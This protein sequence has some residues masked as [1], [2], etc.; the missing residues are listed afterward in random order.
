M[1]V[2]ALSFPQQFVARDAARESDA[3]VLTEDSRRSI[4]FVLSGD[5]PA[6][7]EAVSEALPRLLSL[8][9]NWDGYGSKAIDFELLL[10]AFSELGQI[11]DDTSPRPSMVPLGNG[12][13][14]VEWHSSGR[15]L[16][17]EFSPGQ[18]PAF[19]YYSDQGADD[20]EGELP[21]DRNE[22][23]EILRALV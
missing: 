12:G 10:A 9:N 11:M 3:A 13:V 17:I 8:P 22:L 4:R 19:D 6:W 21:I 18:L 15:H 23:R 20:I 16:E 14:Q 7:A 1:A 2:G 5:L